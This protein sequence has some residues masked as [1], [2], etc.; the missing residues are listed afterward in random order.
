MSTIRAE[1]LKPVEWVKYLI[2]AIVLSVFLAV[3]VPIVSDIL[4]QT[5]T[6][7]DYWFTYHS[8]RPTK[9]VFRVGEEITFYSAREVRHTVDV[10]WHDKL[11]CDTNGQGGIGMRVISIYE[12]VSTLQP[13]SLPFPGK[14]WTYQAEVPKVPAVCYLEST[15]TAV[16]KYANKI[17]TIKSGQFRIK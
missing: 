15:T 9:E 1:L 17:Q 16:L 10:K 4:E 14:P 2:T 7:T 5:Y 8:V 12:S 11:Y 13:H 6:P 3:V